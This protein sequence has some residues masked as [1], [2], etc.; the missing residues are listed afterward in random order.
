MGVHEGEAGRVE[1]SSQPQ[2]WPKPSTWFQLGPISNVLLASSCKEHDSLVSR[3]HDHGP[4]LHLCSLLQLQAIPCACR[5]TNGSCKTQHASAEP[6]LVASCLQ[7]VCW[8]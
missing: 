6:C 2:H 8:T 3:T 1:M 7:G 4:E 5:P